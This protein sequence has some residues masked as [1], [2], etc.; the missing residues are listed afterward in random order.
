MDLFGKKDEDPEPPKRQPEEKK[1]DSPETVINVKQPQHLAPLLIPESHEKGMLGLWTRI[2][3]F[4]LSKEGSQYDLGGA[5]EERVT[6]DLE[7]LYWN[8][9][10]EEDQEA[11]VETRLQEAREYKDGHSRPE[12]IQWLY[13]RCQHIR[14]RRGLLHRPGTKPFQAVPAEAM[15]LEVRKDLDAWQVPPDE[16]GVV[17]VAELLVQAIA[18]KRLC[19]MIIDV[20]PFAGL[21]YGGG[22][23]QLLTQILYWAYELLELSVKFDPRKDMVYRQDR[24]RLSRMFRENLQI[25]WGV[26]EI[27]QFFD[28]WNWGAKEDKG[29]THEVAMY[30]KVGRPIVGACGSIWELNERMRIQIVTHRLE[31]TRWD[32]DLFT[33]E[34][35]LFR[36]YGPPK[37]QNEEENKWG[38]EVFPIKFRGLTE[39]QFRLI[40]ACANK[41]HEIEDAMSLDDWLIKNPEWPDWYSGFKRPSDP[42]SDIE[43][44]I[45]D[46]TGSA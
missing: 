34:A 8:V 40:D 17:Q 30:R 24:K 22:K 21:A 44:A 18:K 39:D 35:Q 27:N 25:P 42:K 15:R 38:L 28:K 19:V 14:F 26:D 33:G 23:S 9:F 13:T 43:A 3:D 2:N 41:T 36:K 46:L 1:T 6:V 37:Y 20:D 10:S 12:Y 31:I 32:E 11:D 4:F 16:A 5:A 7:L 29:N 45:S